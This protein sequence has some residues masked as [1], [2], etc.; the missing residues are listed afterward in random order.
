MLK[1]QTR[2]QKIKNLR[3]PKGVGKTGEDLAVSL[4]LKK[5]FNILERNY[6]LR[7]GE[8]DIIAEKE[9]QIHFFEVKTVSCKTLP[10]VIH[11]TL[12]ESNKSSKDSFLLAQDNISKI[13]CQKIRKCVDLY[14]L[15]KGIDTSKTKIEFGYASV[16]LDSNKRIGRV[17][18][19]FKCVL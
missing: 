3:L 15:E 10:D 4:L 11:E 18:M 8:I 19:S 6:L 16:Y 5:R 14:C 12:P 1:N 7:S 9:D 17:F 13:K 2:N